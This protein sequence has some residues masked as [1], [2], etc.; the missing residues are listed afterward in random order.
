M[1]SAG[2]LAQNAKEANDAKDGVMT[3][4]ACGLFRFFRFFRDREQIEA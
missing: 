3:K 1:R 2:S 4:T